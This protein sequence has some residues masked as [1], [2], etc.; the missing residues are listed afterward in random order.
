MAEC[1]I[2]I[3]KK[4]SLNKIKKMSLNM[5]KNILE[6]AFSAGSSSTHF[7]G[8]LSIVDITATL[9]G[10][11]LN[12][13]PKNPKWEGRDRFI[14]SKGH[15]VLGYYTALHEIGYISFEELQTFEKDG[16]FLFGHPIMKRS[17]GI[18][19]SNG[20][21]GMGLSLGVGVSLSIKI[22]NLNS[23]VYILMGDGECNEGSVWEAAMSASHYQL[24]NIIAII[25]RNN[26]QQTGSSADIMNTA[27][28]VLKW[29]SF[30]WEVVEIDGHDIQQIYDTFSS[31][32]NQDRPIAVIANTIKGK[33]FSLSENNNNWHHSPLTKSQYKLC[34]DEL[35]KKIF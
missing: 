20:S 8:G 25:D 19:F 24:K 32:K 30:N 3:E 4:Y 6:M 14:L 2:V 13:H 23:K 27:D 21:L 5:R 12:F 10:T 33:G 34:M 22:K 9:Y 31:F 11:I 18:E 16:T 29:K 7:G 28:L 1:K 17:K 26:F 15:G 35:N